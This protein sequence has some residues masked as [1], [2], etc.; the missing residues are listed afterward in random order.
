MSY[1]TSRR[2]ILLKF[3]GFDYRRY[4]I[5]TQAQLEKVLATNALPLRNQYE[6]TGLVLRSADGAN[7][8]LARNLIDQ[9]K[10]RGIKFGSP[11]MIPLADTQVVNDQNS[12]YGLAFK[13]N[14][15]TRLVDASI[16]ESDGRFTAQ[17]IDANTGLPTKLG[18]EGRLSYT[19][20]SGLSRL[21][22]SG[23]LNLF[24]SYEYLA[25]S[26]DNGRV[27]VVRDGVAGADLAKYTA[28]INAEFE[29]Q[30]SE[31]LARRNEALKVMR[32]K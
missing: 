31:L 16:L 17:D 19:R 8:Y 25:L 5:A 24:S 3:E 29:G 13:L 21:F 2:L 23:D 30:K 9:I 15:G 20:D 28:E 32:G 4:S 14:D 6:D 11:I 7:E 27:V 12:K 1:I 10:A 22:L 26:D 18:R